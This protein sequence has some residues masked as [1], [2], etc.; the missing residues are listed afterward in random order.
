[1]KDSLPC[2]CLTFLSK[3]VLPGWDKRMHQQAGAGTS[4]ARVNS[5]AYRRTELKAATEI[6]ADKP[7]YG[8]A[9]VFINAWNEWRRRPTSSP[10][11]HY[12]AGSERHREE[13]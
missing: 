9:L 13:P 7:V 11:I 4:L 5:K 2:R 6:A 10:D 8:E 12:G 1:M 3:A